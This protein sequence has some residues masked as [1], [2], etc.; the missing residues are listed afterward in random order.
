[1]ARS[2][3]IEAIERLRPGARFSLDG[4]SLSGLAWHDPVQARPSDAEINAGVPAAQAAWEAA[5][6]V[7][8]RA[9]A[10]AAQGITSEAV[11]E[12]IY[13]AQVQE[14]ASSL[15]DIQTRRDVIDADNP[16]PRRG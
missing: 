4:E 16:V 11:V 2:F 14:N 9:A 6:H 5:A 7:R 12:A 1:M 15:E 3:L 13:A 8:A 10:R